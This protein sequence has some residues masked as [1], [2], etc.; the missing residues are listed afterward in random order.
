MGQK[1]LL[2]LARALLQQNRF[3]ILDEAT[4]NLDS[5]SEALVQKVIKRN[6]KRTTVITIVHRLN[7]IADYDKII[8]IDKGKIVEQGSPDELIE[9]RGVF[10]D[11]VQHTGKN[12][13][14]EII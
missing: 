14:E 12:E 8:V 2:C 11:M 3:L 13:S 7:E 9:G 10:Y 6:F 5:K 1:Q 4:S